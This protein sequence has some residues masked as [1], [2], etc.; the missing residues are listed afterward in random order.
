MW[1]WAQALVQQPA[2]NK[3]YVTEAA[4]FEKRHHTV[5]GQQVK[6][7]SAWTS[8]IR[9]H[10]YTTITHGAYTA[11]GIPEGESLHI[12]VLGVGGRHSN[13]KERAAMTRLAEYSCSIGILCLYFDCDAT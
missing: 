11:E 6:V 4:M 1:W 8:N 2:D 13:A 9:Q 10:I 3:H 12:G 5:D 7:R